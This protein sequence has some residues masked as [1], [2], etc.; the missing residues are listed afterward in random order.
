M[1]SKQVFDLSEVTRA[2]D[3]PGQ[4]QA[5]RSYFGDVDLITLSQPVADRQDEHQWLAPAAAL[6]EPFERA[7]IQGERDIGPTIANKARGL[8]MS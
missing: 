5:L 2:D 8:P 7:A 6:L 3:W 1:T 4:S